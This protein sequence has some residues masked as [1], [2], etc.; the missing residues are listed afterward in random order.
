MSTKKNVWDG[1][2]VGGEFGDTC[3][4]SSCRNEARAAGGGG[5]VVC[6]LFCCPLLCVMQ[7]VE[8]GGGV[9][10]RHALCLWGFWLKLNV[11]SVR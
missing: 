10:R 1:N 4:R 2:E 3:Q 7:V 9:G 5:S 6:L 8:R 11:S